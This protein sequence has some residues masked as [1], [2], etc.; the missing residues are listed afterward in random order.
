MNERR[1]IRRK[2]RGKEIVRIR[3]HVPIRI[4]RSADTF[5]SSVASIGLV[6]PRVSHF[7]E[8]CDEVIV[9]VWV[10]NVECVPRRLF[11]RKLPYPPG[12]ACGVYF[13]HTR[14]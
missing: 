14:A 8:E 4:F 13:S 6:K 7:R 11:T 5:R 3:S 2:Q 10:A 1:G 9:V 12:R